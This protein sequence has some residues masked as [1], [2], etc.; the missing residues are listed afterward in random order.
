MITELQS[1]RES[2]IDRPVLGRLTFKSLMALAGIFG[3]IILIS[4]DYI[5]AFSDP[6]YSFIR[7]SISSLAWAQLGWVQTLGFLAIGLLTEFFVAGLYFSIN[8]RRGFGRGIALLAC[9]GFGLLMIGAFHTDPAIGPSTVDGTIHG[10][11]TKFVFLIFAIAI[12]LVAPTLHGEPYWKSLY[13]YSIVTAIIAIGL[14][15]NSIWMPPDFSWFGLFERILVADEIIWVEI[16]AIGL[17]RLSLR[18]RTV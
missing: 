13:I 17:L 7:H 2:R 10:L 6:G 18:K 14:M 5:V 15:L 1:M 11:A 3:P 12:L 8:G 16:M 9:F 4:T